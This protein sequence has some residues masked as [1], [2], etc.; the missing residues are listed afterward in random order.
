M[1]GRWM[2]VLLALTVSAVLVLTGSMLL[3]MRD[4]G[5]APAGGG[6]PRVPGRDGLRVEVLNAS[7]IPGLAR[8]GTEHLRSHGFDVVFYGNA[9]GFHSD[10][11]L[12]LDRLGGW[13][14]AEAVGRA[15][16]I[17]EVR[18]APDTTLYL[19]VTVI[20]GS[21]WAERSAAR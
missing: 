10:S 3:G 19:D 12:V 15:L 9:S 14:G 5:A 6:E 4:E 18:S 16:G 11:S 13:E 2:A 1:S 8:R 21:D 17:D 20:L 7:G